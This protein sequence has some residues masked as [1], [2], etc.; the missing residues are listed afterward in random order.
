MPDAILRAGAH[1][2]PVIPSDDQRHTP[3]STAPEWSE[4]WS[5]R[6]IDPRRQISGLVR[7]GLW[8]NLGVSRMTVCMSR[9]G[10]PVYHRQ[11]D[12]L[13]L[14]G[15]DVLSGLA[16]GGLSFRCL[17]LHRWRYLI[18]FEDPVAGLKFDLDWQGLHEPADSTE[19]HMPESVPGVGN[20]HLGQLGRVAGRMT[21]REQTFDL[22]GMGARDHSIG[23][24]QWE[25]MNWYDVAWI[26]LD[27]GRAFGLI[28]AQQPAGLL[29]VP[30]I[31]DR[32]ELL[33]LNGMRLEKTLD[34]DFRPLAVSVV[35]F[36]SRGRRYLLSG[37]RRTTM[38]CFADSFV[39]HAGY[40]DFLLDDGTHGIGATEYGYRMGEVH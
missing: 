4:N 25:S 9:D 28:Q 12:G 13:P 31:W 23:T 26:M 18:S 10:R 32:E 3:D 40:F 30:W 19:L 15:G 6:F 38:S 8:P 36:D 24:R 33:P 22:V 20:M 37:T 27:D 7:L 11:L 39:M 17:S 21:F 16:A 2:M 14:P 35:G 1:A 29:Q 34:S 5:F